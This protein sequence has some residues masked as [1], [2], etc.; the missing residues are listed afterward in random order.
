MQRPLPVKFP[1]DS[2]A[3]P[4]Q[5]RRHQCDPAVANVAAGEADIAAVGG[6]DVHAELRGE[7]VREREDVEVVDSPQVLAAVHE[8]RRAET[9]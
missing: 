4:A 7:D 5:R 2:K 8:G 3:Q 1:S 6:A 9:Q